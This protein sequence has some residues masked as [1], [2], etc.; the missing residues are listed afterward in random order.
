MNG[1]P[2][3]ASTSRPGWQPDEPATDDVYGRVH[4]TVAFQ[5]DEDKRD[6]AGLSRSLP[7]S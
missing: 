1:R 5:A 3:E 7:N 2:A 6:P 4:Q